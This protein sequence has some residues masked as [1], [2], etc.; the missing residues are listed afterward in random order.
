[1]NLAEKDILTR[2]ETSRLRFVGHVLRG[3]GLPS[4]LMR[5]LLEE[6]GG[7]AYQQLLLR[8][9]LVPSDAMDREG[10]RSRTLVL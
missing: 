8:N 9:G 3:D 10:W 2:L 6:Y 5:S 7:N 4:I 1:M